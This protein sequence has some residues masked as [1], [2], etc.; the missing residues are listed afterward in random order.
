M[1]LRFLLCFSS[2]LLATVAQSRAA[3][4]PVAAPQPNVLLIL[5]DDQGYGD[6]SLHGNPHLKTPNLDRLGESSVRFER[7]YVHPYCAPSRAAI[8]TG[9]WPLRSGCHG[10]TD[11]TAT[12]RTEEVTL[13]EA[14]KTAGYKTA[15][16]GKWHNGVQFPFTAQGQGFD[17]F[18][19]F[20][21]GHINNY[22]DA[23]LQRGAKPEKTKGY[24]TDV[25][26]DEALR[27]IEAN[28]ASPFF[29]YLAYNAP[30][31]P[32]QV[33]DKYF[34]RLKNRGLEDGPAAFWGM[35]ENIDENVGRLLS[36]LDAMGLA[37]NT[38]VLFM[39]DNGGTGGY[40]IFN[41]GMREGKGS[42]HEGG[43][44][45]PCFMRWPAAKW[46]AR[47][48]GALAAHIDIYPTVLELCGVTAPP[49][50]KVDGRSLCPL[51]Q[52]KA[53]AWPE[54]TLFNY[55]SFS[56]PEQSP[57]GIAVKGAV[58]TAKY[59]LV[60]DRPDP[61]H[62]RPDIGWQLYDMEADPGEKTNLAGAHP[63][64]VAQL[65]RLYE[66]WYADISSRELEKFPISVGY[67]EE[68]PVELHATQ[69]GFAQ[70]PRYAITAFSGG[71]LTGWKKTP[72]RIWFDIDVANAGEYEAEIKFLCPM[73]DA[74]SKIRVS[75]G[76]S[77]AEAVVA[78]TPIREVALP[79][80]GKA[81]TTFTNME[82]AQLR[83]GTLKLDQG[84]CR[85]SIE[86][87]SIPGGQVMDF[88]SIILT[89]PRSP[90]AEPIRVPCPAS[91]PHR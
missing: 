75:A 50:P 85:L 10:V 35:C 89:R 62:K 29:C 44:R 88:K 33:P 32:F 43:S 47:A 71:W 13:A 60:R 56:D 21:G 59:R 7:F 81:S 49:G 37:D 90:N 9:R 20:N 31:L 53:D 3:A 19:G 26:T 54:R 25:L 69:A 17:S 24:I 41:A 23:V 80:R 48:V 12:M 57:G 4:I 68:N 73:A 28:K 45:V 51:L 78:G 67:D 86:A 1:K 61:A 2:V 76:A 65:S 74:G 58:R 70:G 14:L 6:L 34:D 8:L 91:P 22:F 87:L 16:I 66:T 36:A 52:G 77:S 38:I 15:C 46:P 63:E 64:L 79:H 18:F 83:V 72:G 40:P 39:T 42:V 55:T 30:H 11:Q 27:F 84:P 5:T 82:W